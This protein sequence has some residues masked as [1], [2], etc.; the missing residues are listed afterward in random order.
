VVRDA[1]A[2]DGHE[3]TLART[4]AHALRCLVDP[5][6][7]FELLILHTRTGDG[8]GRELVSRIAAQATPTLLVV[9][10]SRD[11]ALEGQARQLGVAGVLHEPYAIDDLRVVT[12]TFVERSA[13]RRGN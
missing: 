6:A 1:L 5:A 13:R 2:L 10:G 11:P 12:S 7:R 3:V 9:D 8:T 4:G